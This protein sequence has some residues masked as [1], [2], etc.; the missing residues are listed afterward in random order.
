MEKAVFRTDRTAARWRPI[1]PHLPQPAKR[2][3]PRTAL[4]HSFD[5]LGYRV[6]T[7][8]QWRELP[9]NFPPWPTVSH[10]FHRW[11]KDGRWNTLNARLRATVRNAVGKDCRPS[12]GILDSQSVKSDPPGGAVGS[13]AGKKIKGRKRHR[14]VDTLGLVLAVRVPPASTPERGGGPG[15]AGHRAGRAHLV[16]EALGRRRLP[17]RGLRPRG[18]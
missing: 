9:K 10:V 16:P 4:R 14:L 17:R 2:G 1:G 13:D 15:R 6:K 12:A 8:G 5:A 7:G 18:P 3:R 11:A